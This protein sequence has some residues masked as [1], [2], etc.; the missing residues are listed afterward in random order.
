[1]GRHNT[2]SRK[3][4]KQKIKK[5]YAK[6]REDAQLA[7]VIPTEPVGAVRNEVVTT[8][9]PPQTGLIKEAL[10]KG[11][12]VPE[13]TKPR[14]VDEMVKI[15]EDPNI[16]TKQKI[17]AFNALR[18]ADQQQF[19]RDHPELMSKLK[20]GTN[21]NNNVTNNNTN[22]VQVGEVFS[23]ILDIQKDIE[24]II[25]EPVGQM[26]I[27][28]KEISNI[29]EDSNEKPLDVEKSNISKEEPKTS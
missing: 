11:W 26:Q 1:M 19:E 3:N 2:N 27:G 14:L 17:A 23:D 10:K 29:R 9:G 7:G 15:V 20:G 5:T 21:I 13:E 24:K 8:S 4:R 12:A 25:G 28:L 18:M 6:A 16:P 22:A